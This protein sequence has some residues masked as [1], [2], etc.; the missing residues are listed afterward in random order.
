MRCP[1]QPIWASSSRILEFAELG[2]LHDDFTLQLCKEDYSKN[3]GTK[4][5]WL[6]PP[7]PV[8]PV[9][10]CTLNWFPSQFPAFFTWHRLAWRP[11][12]SMGLASEHKNSD[13]VGGKGLWRK[14]FQND[15]IS[16]KTIWR[17]NITGNYNLHD[18]NVIILRHIN[19]WVNCIRNTTTK[20]VICLIGYAN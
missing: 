18:L 12:S 16:M 4:K 1:L 14:M 19:I 17:F 8:L 11:N 20:L 7:I 9:P 13:G 5:A 15:K 6:A 10:T 2:E 3:N